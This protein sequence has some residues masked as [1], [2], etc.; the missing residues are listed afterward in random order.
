MSLGDDCYIFETPPPSWENEEIL[1]AND[2]EQTLGTPLPSPP[3]PS[4]FERPGTNDGGA[5]DEDDI[6]CFTQPFAPSP[7]PNRLLTVPSLPENS[8]IR[9]STA[10]R[11][12]CMLK[13]RLVKVRERQEKNRQR[14]ILLEAKEKQL[15]TMSL[16]STL[17]KLVEKVIHG[18]RDECKISVEEMNTWIHECPGFEHV[19]LVQ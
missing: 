6:I 7:S 13:E 8:I 1:S 10:R 11:M 9:E 2:M 3:H 17:D 14:H 18:P 12:E 5:E 15:L 16:V 19:R 4:S